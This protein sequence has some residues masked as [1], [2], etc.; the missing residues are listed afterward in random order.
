[1]SLS[2]RVRKREKVNTSDDKPTTMKKL[3]LL[4]LTS[5]VLAAQT[6]PVLADATEAERE[7]IELSRKAVRA[8]VKVDEGCKAMCEEI[9]KDDKAKKMICEMLSKDPEARRLLKID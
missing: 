5:C 4:T 2:E 6:I 3:L 9:M 7:Q 8:S 1:M